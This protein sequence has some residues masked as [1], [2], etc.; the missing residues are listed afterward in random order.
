MR[1]E[2]KELK[3]SIL[4]IADEI[5]AY[6][7]KRSKIFTPSFIISLCSVGIAVFAIVGSFITI[8]QN[9][10]KQKLEATANAL[11]AITDINESQ[12]GSKTISKQRM[13]IFEYLKETIE[14]TKG[15]QK[16]AFLLFLADEYFYQSD[17][18]N[19]IGLYRQ[20]VSSPHSTINM[21]ELAY[22]E[23]GMIYSDKLKDKKSGSKYYAAAA[24]LDVPKNHKTK[25]YNL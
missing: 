11:K 5:K 14:M 21:K 2:M 1:T 23:M 24:E 4:T 6:N 3:S 18:N 9:I 13:A 22:R 16:L 17:F 12:K 19:S 10:E 15:S 25:T 8:N 20:V 7:S